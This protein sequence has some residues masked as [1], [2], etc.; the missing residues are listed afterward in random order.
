MVIKTLERG[1]DNHYYIIRGTA[2]QLF[3]SIIDFANMIVKILV[4]KAIWKNEENKYI[5]I[6]VVPL[7]YVWIL[8]D[9][10]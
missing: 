2:K 3:T 8:Y 6:D 10:L 7:F 4:E 1:P 9:F 5:S